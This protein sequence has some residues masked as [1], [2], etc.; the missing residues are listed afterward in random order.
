MR[1][2]GRYQSVTWPRRPSAGRPDEPLADHGPG[3]RDTLARQPPTVPKIGRSLG[4]SRQAIQRTVDNLVAL[5][6]LWPGVENDQHEDR[7]SGRGDARRPRHAACASASEWADGRTEIGASAPPADLGERLGAAVA[8]DTHPDRGSCPATAD[9]RNTE[10]ASG[11]EAMRMKPLAAIRRA[12]GAGIQDDNILCRSGRFELQARRKCRGAEAYR[13][14]IR[15]VRR[16]VRPR[17]LKAMGLR[18]T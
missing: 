2:H 9:D 17:P 18:Q 10:M 13:Q 3:R 1:L 12:I 8:I 11:A 16:Y 5:G 15:R 14:M 4:H 7:P 6:L